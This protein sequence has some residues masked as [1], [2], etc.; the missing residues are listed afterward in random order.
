MVSLTEDLSIT[1]SFHAHTATL[2]LHESTHLWKASFSGHSPQPVLSLHPQSFPLHLF[3]TRLDLLLHWLYSITHWLFLVYTQRFPLFWLLP[4]GIKDCSC[5][6]H[7]SE[8]KKSLPWYSY[9]PNLLTQDRG[10]HNHPPSKG[11]LIVP[12]LHSEPL[13]VVFYS[14]CPLHSQA[15]PV[16]LLKFPLLLLLH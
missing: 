14:H 9:F 7:R 16:N 8:K 1:I 10:L 4:H 12:L 15:S 13:K 2:H 3:C 5:I 6:S 11:N